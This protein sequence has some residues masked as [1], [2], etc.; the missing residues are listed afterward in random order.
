MAGITTYL[1]ILTLNV[2]GLDSPTKR[3]HLANCIKNED[4]TICCLQEIHL[5]DSNKHWLMV[6]GPLKQVGVAILTSDKVDFKLT[7]VTQDKEGHFILIKGVIHQKEITII[8]LYIPN[9]SAP[10]FIKHTLKDLKAHIDG[11]TM[12]VGDFNTPLSLIDDRSYKQ[13][14]TKKP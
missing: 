3:H 4:L 2:N 5:I 11:N 9:V 8:N 13:N 12:A 7:L 1:S 10:N 6:K 14:P